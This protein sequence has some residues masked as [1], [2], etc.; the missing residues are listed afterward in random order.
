MTPVP[1]AQCAPSRIQSH[2]HASLEQGLPNVS[3]L[4]AWEDAQ[5]GLVTRRPAPATCLT[6]P[7]NTPER[8]VSSPGRECHIRTRS[9]TALVMMHH[10][11]VFLKTVLT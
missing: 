6:G 1:V 10:S 2:D 7:L 3:P 5:R 9:V 11:A 4:C 8:A